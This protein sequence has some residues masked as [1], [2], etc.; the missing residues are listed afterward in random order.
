MPECYVKIKTGQKPK[1]S[2]IALQARIKN[3]LFCLSCSSVKWGQDYRT[4]VKDLK[5]NIPSTLGLDFLTLRYIL[6]FY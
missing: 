6:K 4:R 5:G 1:A 3:L 2:K